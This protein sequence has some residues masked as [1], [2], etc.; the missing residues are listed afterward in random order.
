MASEPPLDREDALS[1]MG[2]LFDLRQDTQYIIRL[3]EGD[4]GQEEENSEA[5]T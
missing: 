4:D 1:I 5:D 3:L 2:A